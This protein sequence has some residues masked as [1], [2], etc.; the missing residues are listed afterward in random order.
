VRLAYLDESYTQDHYFIGA[1]VVGEHPA[2]ALSR[3]LDAVAERARSA[4]LPELSIPLELHAHPMF[5]AH[6]EWKPLKGR[7]RT[8]ISVY[9]Q[10]MRAIGEQDVD[11][12]FRGLDCRRHRLRYPDPWPEHDVVLRHLLER[13]NDFGTVR[14][15]QVLV[16]ADEIQDAERHR[17]NLSRF[18][19]GG[20]PGY[21]RSRLDHILDTLH[22]APSQHSRLL[23]AA[24]LVTFLYRRRSTIKETDPRQ[25]AAIGRIWGH[26][27]HQVRHE[28]LYV[29]RTHEGPARGGA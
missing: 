7:S 25:A 16:I 27:E 5:N 13:L 14:G 3:T 4:Y 24:D 10:A 17:A 12:F 26:V 2:A 9:D 19:L 20:T 23:Q 18:R 28:W 15:E 22:F 6:H 21:R 29:P 8:L 1:V 11:L